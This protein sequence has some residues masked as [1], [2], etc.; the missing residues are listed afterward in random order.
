[1]QFTDKSVVRKVVS[2]C[3]GLFFAVL[4]RKALKGESRDVVD[5]AFA[6]ARSTCMQEHCARRCL[7]QQSLEQF[8]LLMQADAS[9]LP[10]N[11]H[12]I[13]A[14]LSYGKGEVI[15]YFQNVNEVC[16]SP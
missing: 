9:Q 14:A 10:H 16:G 3:D 2:L 1:M 4:Y 15:W 11:L 12:N 6:T 13:V 8:A 5:R 7:A